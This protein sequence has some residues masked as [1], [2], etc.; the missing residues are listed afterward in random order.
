MK[1]KEYIIKPCPF[2]GKAP[3]V[4]HRVRAYWDDWVVACAY[5][6]RVYI[7]GETERDAAKKW[8]TRKGETK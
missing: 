7:I 2:C 3:Q 8:N 4:E 6:D 5:C 1:K